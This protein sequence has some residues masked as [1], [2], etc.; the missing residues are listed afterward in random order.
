MGPVLGAVLQ[1]LS[2]LEPVFTRMTWAYDGGQM[3]Y[4]FGEC[5]SVEAWSTCTNALQGNPDKDALP[6]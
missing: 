5:G 1:G 4:M 2:G 3:L 6:V